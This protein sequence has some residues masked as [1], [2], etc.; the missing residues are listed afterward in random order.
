MNK[1]WIPLVA[2]AACSRGSAPADMSDFGAVQAEPAPVMV[3]KEAGG[4]AVEDALLEAPADITTSP[5][6]NEAA[7]PAPPTQKRLVYYN[8]FMEL[9]VTEPQQTLE[10]AVQMAED[11][12]GYVETFAGNRIVLRVPVAV[13]RSIYDDML[14]LGEIVSRSVNAQDITEAYTSVE[15]RLRT[16]RASRDRLIELLAR[17]RTEEEKLSLL[18]EIK[19]LTERVDQLEMQLKTLA[20]LAS[21]SRITVV[22]QP[23]RED[24][25]STEAESVAAFRW[26]RAL[27]PFKRDVAYD[28]ERLDLK[29]PTGMVSLENREHWMAESADGAQIWTHERENNPSGTTQFW[30]DA[31]RLRL[32]P[33]YASADVTTIGSF[34]TLRLEDG[35]PEGYRYLVGVNV[36]GDDLHVVEIYFPTAEHEKRYR[37]A[38][39]AS[40]QRGEV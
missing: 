36:Q 34:A 29:A 8:G 21:F 25:Y 38:V 37:E 35:G 12:G 13:F 27:S 10:R 18:R 11:A 40:L 15:L 17:A 24:V 16:L 4:S 7:K 33:S 14:K 2:L 28:G 9:R 30:I 26:I 20:T 32:G 3:R 6:R 5:A 39:E 19:R 31:I 22:T 1:W 23:K